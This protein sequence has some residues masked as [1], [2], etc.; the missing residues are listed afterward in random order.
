[1]QFNFGMPL[2][3]PAAIQQPIHTYYTAI[4]D[5]EIPD[6]LAGIVFSCGHNL[7]QDH[8][9]YLVKPVHPKYGYNQSIKSVLEIIFFSRMLFPPKK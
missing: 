9:P 4:P 3:I 2:Q 1:M 5:W 8:R 7:I 6:M